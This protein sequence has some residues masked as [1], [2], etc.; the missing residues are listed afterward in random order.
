MEFPGGVVSGKGFQ[1]LLALAD[2]HFIQVLDLEF[3]AKAADGSVRVIPAHDVTVG[4]GSPVDMTEF[5]GASSGIVSSLDITEVASSI[6]ADSVAAI[7]VYEELTLLPVIAAWENSGAS[8]VAGGPILPED[9]LE[10]INLA[11]NAS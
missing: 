2:A 4:D 5:D 11:D 10:A 1:L 7:L 6:S 9:L 8:L 3:V